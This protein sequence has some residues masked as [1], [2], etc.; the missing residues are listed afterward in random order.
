MK[1]ILKNF[2]DF[3]SDIENP[4]EPGYDPVHLVSMIVVVLLALTLLFWLL[5][6]LLVFGGGIQSK[7]FPLMQVI[8]TSKNVSDFGYIGYP[9]EMGVFDGWV[10]NLVALVFLILLLFGIWYIFNRTNVH[11]EKRENESELQ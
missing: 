8:F 1:K 7:I 2:F 5:W 11:G 3:F 9:Y 4:D 6:A 10:T